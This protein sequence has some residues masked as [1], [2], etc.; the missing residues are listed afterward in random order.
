MLST[1]SSAASSSRSVLVAQITDTHIVE[2]GERLHGRVDASAMLTAAVSHLNAMDPRPDVVLATGDLVNDG[3]PAQYDELARI[4]GGL[5]APVYVIPGNHD[6]RANL[7]A[8]LPAASAFDQLGPGGSTGSMDGV[9]DGW[10][11]RLIGLD[12]TIPGE[13]GGRIMAAQMTWLDHVLDA[14]PDRPTLIFQHHPPFTTGIGWM[15]E[16]GLTDRHLE[17]DVIG[18]H[19]NVVGIVCGHVHRVIMAPFAGTMA[20]TWPS[21]GPQV[22]LALDGTPNGYCD[23]PATVALHRWT[24]DDGLV[25]HV[26][27]V[28]GPEAWLPPWAQTG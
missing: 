11:L 14:E 9:V 3:T 23:E 27:Y 17:A 25:S 8:A 15:D 1:P 13:H 28:G 12:T 6:D 5:T 2:A 22:A 21:T 24:P 10:P 26:D 18:R 7:R 16:V 20:S 4:L 19:A